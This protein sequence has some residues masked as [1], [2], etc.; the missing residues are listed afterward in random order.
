MISIIQGDTKNVT[1]TLTGGDASIVDTLVFS[2]MGLG[3]SQEL[4]KINDTDWMLIF[5][6]EFT[7]SCRLCTTTF[8][9]TAFCDDNQIQTVVYQGKIEVL[10][11]VNKIR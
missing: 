4:V 11:K 7:S 9:L 10:K 5:D 3:V 2:S 8:D 1:F 6:S